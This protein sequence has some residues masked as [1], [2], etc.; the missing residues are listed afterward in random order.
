LAD[1]IEGRALEQTLHG[2]SDLFER[3]HN[4]PVAFFRHPLR[5]VALLR[6]R[7]G[8][9]L[10]DHGQMELQRLADRAGARFPDK[11]I[12][13]GHV[14]FDVL[15]ESDHGDWL[16]GGQILE[17]R[18]EL[19]VVPAYQN[20]LHAAAGFVEFSRDVDHHLRPMPSE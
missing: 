20:Q 3:W 2:G 17:S 4:H 10:N 9:A 16:L 8:I 7:F 11:E 19:P 13:Q 5:V 15:C 1:F 12:G 14:V 18:G 6:Q